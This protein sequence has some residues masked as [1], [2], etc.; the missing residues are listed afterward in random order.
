MGGQACVFYGAA[1]FSRDLDLLVLVEEEQLGRLRAALQDLDADPVAVPELSAEY[2]RRGHAV[3]FRCR[4][5][6][7]SGLRI[8]LM[9][10]LRGLPSFEEMWK[11]RTTFDV[12]GE[13]INAGGF[14]TGKKTQRDKDWPMIRRLVEQSYYT[15]S[16]NP[17][18]EL[19]AFWLHE[20]RTPVLLIEASQLHPDAARRV[21]VSRPAVGAALR[22]D[23]DA[24]TG[25]LEDEERAERRLDRE[26]WEPLKRE[27]E[28]LRRAR[29]K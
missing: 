15:G 9:A 8:D 5:P 6:D 17:A 10:R 24:V 27:L 3:R 20:L 29:R 14:G 1:E 4:R 23:V 28:E 12:A 13:Q 25:S 22:A 19:V 26:F 16:D 21:S 18:S 7:V 11:R 2:L